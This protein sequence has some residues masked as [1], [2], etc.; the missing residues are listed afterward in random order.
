M[1]IQE[2]PWDQHLWKG[3]GNRSGSREKSS[4]A[5]KPA[6]SFNTMKSS[7]AECPFRVVLNWHGVAEHPLPC[8]SKERTS[9]KELGRKVFSLSSISSLRVF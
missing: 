9:S 8:W 3:G 7:G 6:A 1:F 5:A 4:P 2:H